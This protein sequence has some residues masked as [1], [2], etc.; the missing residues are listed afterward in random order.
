MTSESLWRHQI[1]IRRTF[2]ELVY[3]RVVLQFLAQCQDCAGT[4]TMAALTFHSQ[5]RPFI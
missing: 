4:V 5:Y 1:C 2:R 3:F